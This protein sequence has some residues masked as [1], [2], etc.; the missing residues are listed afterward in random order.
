MNA[1][2]SSPVLWEVYSLI[3]LNGKI[4]QIEGDI[5]LW[6]IFKRFDPSCPKCKANLTI[7]NLVKT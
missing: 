4:N 3:D 2:R 6:E 7:D 5:D 1:S